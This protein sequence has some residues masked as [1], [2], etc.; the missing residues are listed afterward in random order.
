MITK[1]AFAPAFVFHKFMFLTLHDMLGFGMTTHF[2]NIFNEDHV[3]YRHS[4][5]P[6]FNHNLHN[7][8]S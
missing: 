5:Y 2:T 7:R 3:Q 4:H 8:V 1:T 6:S